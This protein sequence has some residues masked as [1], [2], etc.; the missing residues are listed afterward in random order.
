M[1][2]MWNGYPYGQQYDRDGLPVTGAHP[3]HQNYG[4]GQP[5]QHYSQPYPQHFVPPAQYPPAPAYM[6]QP[7][8][9]PTKP[10]NKVVAALLFFFLGELGIGNF[11]MG[12]VGRGVTK[13][14]LL[15]VTF[16][17]A[18]TI[19]GLI[20]ALPLAIVLA[21]WPF[22]EMILVLTGTGGYDRDGNGVPLE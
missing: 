16:I 10:K 5:A 13:L 20:V 1:S 9:Y 21:I 11:Y 14:I 18:I 6:V 2:S 7:Y 22:V 3:G 15:A 19:I 8:P 17:L 4:Y 12:Q